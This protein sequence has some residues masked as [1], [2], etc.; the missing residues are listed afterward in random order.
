MV[1]NPDLSISRARCRD[2]ESI[3]DQ[4]LSDM[5]NLLCYLYELPDSNVITVQ[6][7]KAIVS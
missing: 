5:E 4:S 7:L 1:N 2:L 3:R 6:T